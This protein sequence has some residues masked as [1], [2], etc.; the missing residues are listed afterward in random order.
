MNSDTKILFTDLDGTLLD[1]H[2]QIS[3]K[4]LEAIRKALAHGHK[5]VISTGRALPS[6]IVQSE[7]LGLTMPG[8]YIIAY[9]G[10][11]IYDSFEKKIIFSQTLPREYVNYLF[12]EAHRQ[13]LHVHTYEDAYVVTE[14]ENENLFQYLRDTG[15]KHR[16]VSSVKKELSCDPP[17]LLIVDY[18]NHDTLVRFQESIKDWS[19]GKVDSFFSSDFL[20]EVVSPGISKGNAIL[21]LCQALNLPLENT[22][23]AGDAENDISML[24]TTH[25]SVVMKNANPEMY[26]YAT[27]V[28]EH[29]NNHDGI[30]EVIYK[31]ML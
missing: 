15:L 4:N 2:K 26:A 31:F 9:N 21:N 20:L 1:D 11:S 29:D 25:T 24:K 16:V 5:I 23:S 18:S 3:E 13:S 27:Y 7:K 28:T 22:I 12:E 19:V 30:A 8:C 17:K 10:A 6:A 14:E